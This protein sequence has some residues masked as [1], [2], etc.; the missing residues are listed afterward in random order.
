MRSR[1]RR[2]TQL[3]PNASTPDPVSHPV[4]NAFLRIENKLDAVCQDA[5][6]PY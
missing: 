2:L 6:I 4:D 5:V 3:M 1:I